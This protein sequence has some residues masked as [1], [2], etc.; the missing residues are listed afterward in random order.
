MV[1]SIKKNPSQ[2]S[3]IANLAI[4]YVVWG[5]TYLAVK[6]SIIVLPPMLT[7][8]LRFLVGGV[9]LLSFSILKGQKLPKWPQVKSAIIVGILLT[10]I[11]TTLVAYAIKYMPSGLV[12]LLV[13]TLPV[14]I[15]IMDFLFF[16]KIKPDWLITLGLFVGLLGLLILF[17]PFGNLKSTEIVLWPT[18]LVLIGSISWGYGSLLS[19]YLSMPPQM[20]STSIQM[21]TGGIVAAIGSFIFEPNSFSKIHLMTHE[22]YLALG[23]LIFIGS[24]VGFSS[25]TWLVSNAPPA[26]VSTYAYVNP[27]IAMLLGWV[28]VGEKLSLKTVLASAVVLFGVI[29]I[30]L[31]RRKSRFS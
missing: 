24:F 13:A 12:A 8:C 30:T 9:L 21:I 25:Y 28:F 29:L 1:S 6:Y 26:L 27:V 11:G 7:S 4:V 2:F 31:G 14:W 22:T 10:G 3:L 16:T 19:P 15:A 23:Y 5:S 20:Q 18:I 17:N